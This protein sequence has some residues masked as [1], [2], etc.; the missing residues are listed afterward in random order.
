MTKYGIKWDK[1]DWHSVFE[2][3]GDTGKHGCVEEAKKEALVAAIYVWQNI[4]EEKWNLRREH[5]QIYNS[6]EIARDKWYFSV[7]V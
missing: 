7:C 1:G 5:V 2:M 6:Q 4:E 3:V